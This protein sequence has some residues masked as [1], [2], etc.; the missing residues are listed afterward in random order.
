M[1][2]SKIDIISQ[3]HKVAKGIKW[4]KVFG[5]EF[6]KE[7]LFQKGLS[8]PSKKRGEIILDD[9]LRALHVFV[10]EMIFV[11]PCLRER[12]NDLEF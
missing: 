4:A 8:Q 5:K 11:S 7:P 2:K 9:F 10:V 3:R 12:I 1:L 6:E